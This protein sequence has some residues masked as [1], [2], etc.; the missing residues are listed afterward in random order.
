VTDHELVLIPRDPQSVQDVPVLLAGLR[1]LGLLGDALEVGQGRRF[2]PGEALLDLLTFLGCSPQVRLAPR[3][4]GDPRFCH[5][6]LRGP[7]PEPRL[8]QAARSKPPRCPHCRGRLEGALGACA[9]RPSAAVDCP[10]CGRS[11]PCAQVDW[12]R[13]AGVAR[14]ALVVHEVFE[15]EAVPAA[16]LLDALARLTDGPWDYFYR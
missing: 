6:E 1:E 7:W 13:S 2:L 14:M 16:R 9:Q 8:L 5:L 10:G 15:G 11:V 12:R 3:G 4:E